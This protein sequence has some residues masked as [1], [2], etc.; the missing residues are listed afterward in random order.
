MDAE[1]EDE[2]SRGSGESGA[3][4]ENQRRSWWDYV[5]GVSGLLVVLGLAVYTLGL[6][7][8]WAPIATTYTHDVVTA[9]H[10]ASL[11]PRPVVVGLGVRQLVAFPLI[12]T[13][14]IL[15]LYFVVY[16]LLGAI[17]KFWE[18]VLTGR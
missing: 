8:L 11:V 1:N 14:T 9:W 17:A 7:A 16:R 10:A 18:F 3:A 6:F 13:I 15:G 2:L 5:A 12:A 4:N